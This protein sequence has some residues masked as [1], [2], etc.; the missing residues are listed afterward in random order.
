MNALNVITP[1]QREGMW[2]FDDGSSRARKEP[3]ISG[4]DQVNHIS[5]TTDD[6]KLIFLPFNIR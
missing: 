5:N 4:A 1:Y 6:L 2:V 3:F